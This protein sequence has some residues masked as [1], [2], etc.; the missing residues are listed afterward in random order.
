MH[1][2]FQS[3]ESETLECSPKIE[4]FTK[5][6]LQQ[7]FVIF[8]K[9]CSSCSKKNSSET[10]IYRTLVHCLVQAAFDFAWTKQL[11]TLLGSSSFLT[12]LG[13]SSFVACWKPS[14]CWIFS[15]RNFGCFQINHCAR[16]NTHLMNFITTCN[17]SIKMI[18]KTTKSFLLLF[19]GSIFKK[20]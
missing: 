10:R 18:T 15:S 5:F 3:D 6:I 16:R 7:N 4:H 8:S 14:F 17:V 20:E 11:L 19:Y 12:S 2:I 1:A 9:L 13:P